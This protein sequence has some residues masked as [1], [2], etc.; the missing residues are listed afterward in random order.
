MP[1]LGGG[2]DVASLEDEGDGR[3]LD[4]C[5][6]LVA[7]LGDGAQRGRPTGRVCRR[8]SGAPGRDLGRATAVWAAAR[9]RPGV[10]SIAEMGGAPVR[11]PFGAVHDPTVVSASPVPGWHT[12]C[13]SPQAR[14]DRQAQPKTAAPTAGTLSPRRV[15][16]ARR[17]TGSAHPVH[18]HRARVASRRTPPVAGG[19]HPPSPRPRAVFRR[20][21]ARVLRVQTNGAQRASS[22][23]SMRLLAL[24]ILA[25]LVALGGLAVTPT[26]AAAASVKVVVIVGPVGSSTASYIKSAKRYATQA[27]SLR[28]HRQRD[29]QPER[30][31]GQGQGRGRGREHR[32]LPRS[33]QRPSQPL[34]CLLRRPQGRVR[35]Q[36]VRRAREQQQQVL[37]RVLRQDPASCRRTRSSSSTAS[38]TPR[39]TRSG[40]ARTRPSRPPRSASTTT[41]PGS[42]ARR[43]GR[44]FANGI[45]SI[46]SIIRSLLTTDRPI[47]PD[48]P[49]RSAWTGTRDFKFA[50][51]RTTGY[52]AWMDPYASSRY[53]HSVIGKLTLT[54]SQVRAGG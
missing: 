44:V 49:G 21:E 20:E 54:A 28:R 8:S 24:P 5:R 40:A 51:S 14:T 42:C 25:A 31:V 47:G 27:R 4:R 6:G 13:P 15:P 41:A 30:H 2:E 17:P 32:H 19:T 3:G 23:R 45:D 11:S 37:R 7:L 9:E 35:T 52:T 53:Y 39:A 50:S 29:L 1:G 33:R 48:L 18:A 36:Q 16:H 22:S 43:L 10:A 46:S 12:S 38:A 34:R 26:P